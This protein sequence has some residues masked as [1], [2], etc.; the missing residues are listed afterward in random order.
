MSREGGSEGSKKGGE[1]VLMDFV[2]LHSTF[3]AHQDI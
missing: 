3:G 1:I 2:M